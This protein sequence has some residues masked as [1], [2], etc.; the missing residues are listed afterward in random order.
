[1]NN[2]PKLTQADEYRELKSDLRGKERVLATIFTAWWAVNGIMLALLFT[3]ERLS[4][5]LLIIV[6]FFGVVINLALNFQV[7]AITYVYSQQ[8][9]KLRKLQRGPRFLTPKPYRR[10]LW[11]VEISTKMVYRILGIFSVVFWFGVFSLG[12]VLLCRF[13]LLTC[14]FP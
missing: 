11:K 12:F 2:N 5:I 6:G 13:G 14:L 7:W 8:T 10:Y 1:M 4:A 3:S 9:E